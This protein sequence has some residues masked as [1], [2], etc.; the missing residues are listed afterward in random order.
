VL[1]FGLSLSFSRGQE[2]SGKM[3]ANETEIVPDL[4]MS[5]YESQNTEGTEEFGRQTPPIP[6]EFL[7][8]SPLAL[9]PET[10]GFG[11][12]MGR[13]CENPR[14]HTPLFIGAC[15]IRNCEKAREP[16]LT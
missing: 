16:R 14:N 6:V 7:P 1:D 4:E 5:V 13:F 15:G 3:P 2:G 8:R 11:L 12:K 10:P 9:L